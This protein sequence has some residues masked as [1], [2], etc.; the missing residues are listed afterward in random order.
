MNNPWAGLLPQAVQPA[1]V[2]FRVGPTRTDQLRTLLM[3]RGPLSTAQIVRALPEAA[4]TTAWVTALLAPDIKRGYV[5][6]HE[7]KWRLAA[8]YDPRLP[9][10]VQNAITLLRQHG[11]TVRRE[12]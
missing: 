12:A 5:Y 6:K 10:K 2:A 8:D 4:P 9:R 3:E 11:Y 1:P 7:G